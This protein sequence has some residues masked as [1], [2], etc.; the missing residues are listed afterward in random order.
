MKRIAIVDTYPS[1]GTR[2]IGDYLI[3]RSLRS[4]LE[5][6]YGSKLFISNVF[7]AAEWDAVAPT[8]ES[9]DHILFACLPV[10]SNLQDHIYPYLRKIIDGGV[11]YSVLAAGTN[12][13]VSDNANLIG[14]IDGASADAVRELG[15]GA[16]M[17]TTRGALSQMFYKAIGVSQAKCEGDI[18]FYHPASY[19]KDFTPSRKISRIVISDPHRPELYVDSLHTL[20]NG[21]RALA[22]KASIK[23]A[24]HGVNP[25]IESYCEANDVPTVLLYED[26]EDGLDIYSTCDLHVGYRVHAHVSALARRIPSYLLEQDGRG[27][28]YGLFF[29]RKSSVSHF[30]QR[31]SGGEEPPKGVGSI[32]APQQLISMIALD[33][34]NGFQRF[35]GWGPEIESVS[36]RAEK[37][38]SSII[39]ELF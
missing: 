36:R 14:A 37:T 17:F 8:I 5:D 4:I 30:E 25:I 28:D 9:A 29:S 34:G 24:L 13:P 32:S 39:D 27:A 10:R 1:H 7:R 19:G 21:L 18:A 11:P 38:V 3:A 33:M 22:P 2:N 15:A 20:I 23:V 35:A 6:R 12:L 16:R 31:V 26:P